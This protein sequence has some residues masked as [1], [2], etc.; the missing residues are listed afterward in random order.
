MSL[1]APPKMNA[2]GAGDASFFSAGFPKL[3]A[4]ADVSFSADSDPKEAAPDV[5]EVA[6]PP[7][8]EPDVGSL[9]VPVLLSDTVVVE[10]ARLS[11]FSSDGAEGVNPTAA[12][13][14]VLSELFSSC[15]DSPNVKLPLEELFSVLEES[16]PKTIL[17][18]PN[19]N[20]EAAG[21]SVLLSSLDTVPN[22]MPSD[23]IPNLNPDDVV[24]L[25]SDEEAPNLNIPGA[26]EESGNEPPNLKLP[27]SNPDDLLS[28]KPNLIPPEADEPNGEELFVPVADEPKTVPKALDSTLA[29]G[30]T[31]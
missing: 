23:E 6:I 3:N 25:V 28:V 26:E 11:L 17:L 1:L 16:V 14:E 10:G 15:F 29:P 27:D 18:L 22:L 21:C 19:L 24:S 31:A 4:G 2:D 9:M 20:P 5:V 8:T 13:V 30:L 12:E 7:N